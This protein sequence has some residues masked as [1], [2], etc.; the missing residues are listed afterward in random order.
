MHDPSLPYRYRL[1]G[2]KIASSLELPELVD[3]A[4]ADLPDVIITM[5]AGA[6]T[7]AF[8]LHVPDIATF[9]V[10]GGH[11]INIDAESGAE[12]RN[13]RLFLLGSAMG[14]LIHQRGLLPLHANAVIIDGRAIA[15]TGPSGSGKSTLAAWFHDRGFEV[16]AD[17]VCVI[18]PVDELR[19]GVLPGLPR[20]RLWRD[21]LERSGRSAENHEPSFAGTD[22]DRDKFDVSLPAVP[23]DRSPVPLAGIFALEIAEEVETFQLEAAASLRLLMENTYRGQLV[24]EVGDRERYFAACVSL[25][26]EVRV[27]MLRRP[28]NGLAFESIA[29]RILH[30]ARTA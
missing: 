1:F 13:I 22:D 16:L 28:M 9:Y 6:D 21:A 14:A 19:F 30:L 26:R 12:P 15:F 10:T 8:R 25:A 27:W 7:H 3:D 5:E 20:L 29:E 24:D 23:P 11:T 2:L 17:D 4:N 18:S